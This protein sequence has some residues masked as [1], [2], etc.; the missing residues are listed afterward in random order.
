MKPEPNGHPADPD[1][2]LF[3]DR[4]GKRAQLQDIIDDGQDGGYEDRIPALIKLQSS[5]DPYHRL[6]ANV[7]LTSWGEPS[8]F[9]TLTE[10]ARRPDQTPW[11]GS[12]VTLDRLSGSDSAFEMLADAVRA[13]YYSK[14]A[15]AIKP[16]QIEAAKALLPVAVSSYVGR[17]LMLAITHDRDVTAALEPQLRQAIEASITA[18]RAGQKPDFDLPTQT[19]SLL[20][21]M[22]RLDDATTA[23]YGRELMAVVPD[24]VRMLREIVGALANGHGPET[25]KL[26]QSLSANPALAKDV[27]QALERRH[28]SSG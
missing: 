10:W 17:N 21:P 6:L 24:N 16:L 22:A 23:R 2:L 14:N 15:D 25:L 19:A 27:A 8:G 7:M 3:T 13:S 18:L 9:K 1:G 26:L 28:R 4:Q 11:A 5:G 20:V 12:P